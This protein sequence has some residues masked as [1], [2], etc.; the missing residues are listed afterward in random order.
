MQAVIL[1]GGEGTRLRPL[2]L[3]RP[4]P[5]VP[6]VNVPFLHY[7]IGFLSRHGITDI[8]LSCSH[9]PDAIKEVMGNGDALGVRLRYAVEET[10]L[11]TG[12]GVKNAAQLASERLVVLNGDVLTDVD[13]TAI[14]ESHRARS[15]KVTIYLMTVA[16]TSL[17]GVVETEPGGRVRRF[18]EKPAPGQS[19]AN[20]VNGGIYVIEPEVLDLIPRG[21]VVSIE[22]EFFPAL[23]ERGVPFFGHHASAYWIDIG[24]HGKYRQAHA[25]L[26]G[27]AVSTPI[28]PP[29]VKQGNLWVGEEAAVSPRAVLTGPAVIGREVSLAPESRIEPFSVLGDRCVVEARGAVEGAVLWEDVWVGE[30]ASLQGCI[31]GPGCRIGANAT[32][33]PGVVLGKNAVIPDF[34]RL[35]A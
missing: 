30:G 22:R 2:T 8:I 3:A 7:Q 6:L 14:L 20:T 16:D 32:I 19:A 26:L 13:L 12:G 9:R 18:T 4:K 33:G 17:Y 29:G 11:G 15:A 24:T 35:S 21:Q 23:V 25:D 34:S 10:P 31:I 28:T 1:A 27:G 5:I